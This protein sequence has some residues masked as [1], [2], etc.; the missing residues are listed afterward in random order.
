MRRAGIR[1]RARTADPESRT[2]Y[3]ML[4]GAGLVLIVPAWL[5]PWFI[6]QIPRGVTKKP[7][8]GFSAQDALTNL[9][10]FK[11]TGIGSFATL[12][13]FLCMMSLL[14]FFLF[15]AM[16]IWLRDRKAG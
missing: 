11:P 16:C 14:G 10:S 2:V 13:L 15:D 4:H 9:V 5:L 1:G 6:E 3:W 8:Y 7:G 12:L